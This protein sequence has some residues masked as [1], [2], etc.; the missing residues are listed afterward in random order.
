MSKK[1]KKPE[2]PPAS[3]QEIAWETRDTFLS[4]RRGPG[5]ASGLPVR[6]VRHIGSTAFSGWTDGQRLYAYANNE[7]FDENFAWHLLDASIYATIDVPPDGGEDSPSVGGLICGM[8]IGGD[9]AGS[10]FPSSGTGGGASEY[11]LLARDSRGRE[12]AILGA[13]L[14]P[15]AGSAIYSLTNPARESTIVAKDVTQ[16]RADLNPALM[17][18]DVN[19]AHVLNSTNWITNRFYTVDLTR[20][21][22]R[23]WLYQPYSVVEHDAQVFL[24]MAGPAQQN[25]QV[26]V[27]TRVNLLGFHPEDFLNGSAYAFLRGYTPILPPGALQQRP[28]IG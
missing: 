6:Q 25:E 11:Q 3:V 23:N 28:P 8:Q 21:F 24:L 5:G 9:R 2:A 20:H 1:P 13:G 19:Y 26:T 17:P 4:T 16:D 18:A 7:T 15:T 27:Q 12:S 10:L 14:S 22:P